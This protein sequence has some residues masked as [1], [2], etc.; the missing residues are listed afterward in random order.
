MAGTTAKIIG[1]AIIALLIGVAIGYLIKPTA[2][3]APPTGV[4]EEEY[5]RV[6][7]ENEELKAQI[8]SLKSQISELESKLKKPFEGVKIT[9]LVHSGH[10]ANPWKE[11]AD[12][13][14]E[15]YGIE[16]EIVESPPEEIYTKALLGIREKPAKY[17]I[18]QFNSAFIAE[19]APY[20]EPLDEYIKKPGEGGVAWGDILPAF[21]AY[22]NMWAGKIYSLTLDG[23][24]FFLYYRKDL[25]E[26]P[27]EKEA[28]KA[29][30]GYDLR[31][32]RTWKEFL[33]IAEFFTRK[34]GETLCGQPLQ[35]DFYGA[36]FQLKKPRIFY[37]YLFVYW[38]HV[39]AATGGNPHYFDPQTMK[40]LINSEGAVEALET[41]KK[42]LDYMPP[43]VLAWEWD[44]CFTA[45]MKEGYV[46]MTI[47]WPD[48]GKRAPELAPLPIPNPPTPEL[49]VALPP[50]VEKEGVLYQYTMIDAAWV[51]GIAKN[52]KNKEAA[53]AVLSFMCSPEHDLERV[54]APTDYMPDTG[55]DPYRFSHIYSA[56]FLALKPHFAIMTKAYEE[57]ATHGFPLLK[58][59]GAYEYLESLATHVHAYLSGE[60]PDAKTALDKVADDWDKITESFGVEKQKEAYLAMWGLGG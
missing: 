1:I 21:R 17:D 48:E 29:K 26:C 34:K 42:A 4:P 38:P 25:F 23:D 28:F 50:G 35:R 41:L 56:R 59:P 45:F 22:Q 7:K 57:A 27:T 32:P 51:A 49:G 53:W 19:L 14:K 20:L 54:M 12:D 55:H 33:D 13:I 18:I 36:A 37:W 10:Q 8:E 40:P 44:E 52:S 2:P 9:V 24:I 43:G 6:V 60:I 47:H 58:I 30:Y 39:A 46:A 16:L 11:Y 3:P 5:N 15:L 31:P